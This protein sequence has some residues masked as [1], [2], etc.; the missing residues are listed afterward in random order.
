MNYLDYRTALGIGFNDTEKQKLFINRMQVYLQSQRFSE[1]DNE[2]EENFCYEIGMP[3]LLHTD[4]LEFFNPTLT[5]PSGFQRVW[6]YL[7]KKQSNF[8][9][10]LAAL[11]IFANSYSGNA[12]TKKSVITAIKRGLEESNIQFDIIKDKDGV[13]IF[14]KG[15]KELDDKLVT[16]PLQWLTEYPKART[17]WIKALKAYADATDKNASDSADSFRKALE[18]FFREFFGGKKSLEKYQSEYG[19]F[20]KAHGIPPELSNFFEKVLNQYTIYIN[21]YAKHY[22]G[23][24]KIALE[25]IMYQTGSL[26][27]F[28]ITLKQEEK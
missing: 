24:S 11:I 4:P 22:D 6:L 2:Q 1:F 27:R 10:F 7:S 9:D 12:T 5:S 28:L 21:N 26:I 23:T 20:I 3:C 18:Q 25:Y 8:K 13:F 19:N 16:K 17:A 15:A 14:P